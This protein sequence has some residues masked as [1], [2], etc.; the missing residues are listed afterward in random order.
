MFGAQNCSSLQIRS[1]Y[2]TVY[3]WVNALR[4]CLGRLL[5]PEQSYSAVLEVDYSCSLL[6]IGLLLVDACWM[7]AWIHFARQYLINQQRVTA[8]HS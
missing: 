7:G 3:V 5:G 1:D 2:A 4:R 8:L 6:V